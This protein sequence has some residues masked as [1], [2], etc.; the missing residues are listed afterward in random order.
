[1]NH[2]YRISAQAHCGMCD[3]VPNHQLQPITT[4]ELCVMR[5][6]K[7]DDMN[8]CSERAREL[9]AGDFVRDWSGKMIMKSDKKRETGI[10]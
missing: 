5:H 2:A 10:S 4:A 9:S 6:S 1:M 7:G 3:S 8:G